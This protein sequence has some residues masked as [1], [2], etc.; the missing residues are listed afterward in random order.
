LGQIDALE[1]S[2]AGIDK[3]V[4]AL[5]EPFRAKANRLMT[6]PGIS[7]V[8]AEV[9]VS[10]IGIDM[11][12]FL[13]RSLPT[14]RRERRQAPLDTASTGSAMAQGHSGTGGLVCRSLQAR[15]SACAVFP[16]QEPTGTQESHHGRR[17]IHVDCGI[18]HSP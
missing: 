12:H 13:G 6:I 14:Q 9:I 10:E 15:I 18:L 4:G 16:N 8:A 11:S 3:E 17:S 7:D 2:I 5:L 1:Q